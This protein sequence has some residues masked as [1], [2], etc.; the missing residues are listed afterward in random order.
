MASVAICPDAANDT[1]RAGRDGIVAASA[2]QMGWQL[3]AAARAGGALA[4]WASDGDQHRAD[5]LRRPHSWTP[6]FGELGPR[7]HTVGTAVWIVDLDLVAVE[8]EQDTVVAQLGLPV[9]SVVQDHPSV[10]FEQLREQFGGRV[11]P[12]GHRRKALPAGVECES[13]SSRGL[14]SRADFFGHALPNGKLFAV[15]SQ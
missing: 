8:P 13:M 4:R 12:K 10:G 2:G 14:G 3:V 11:C 1:R 5:D 6:Q 7:Q 15:Q 9:E